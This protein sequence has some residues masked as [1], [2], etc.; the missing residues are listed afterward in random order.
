[1]RQPPGARPSGPLSNGGSRR[2]DAEESARTVRPVTPDPGAL[3][4]AHAA[5]VQGTGAQVVAGPLAL[6]PGVRRRTVGESASSAVAG[7]IHRPLDPVPMSATRCP[8]NCSDHS[9]SRP[10]SLSARRRT[11]ELST[12]RQIAHLCPALRFCTD[13]SNYARGH[14]K[15]SGWIQ[16]MPGTEPI[17]F[18]PIGGAPAGTPVPRRAHTGRRPVIRSHRRVRSGARPRRPAG[19]RVTAM[20]GADLVKMTYPHVRA[21]PEAPE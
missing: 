7:T 12:C 17:P 2:G 21:P 11:H 18:A 1:M 16:A 20:C 4:V 9:H 14:A 8:A 3:P 5:T 15:G 19:G 10:S 13:R 6:R